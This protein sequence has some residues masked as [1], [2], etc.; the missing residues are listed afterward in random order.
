MEN[1]KKLSF[2]G[3]IFN[4]IFTENPILILMIGM[5]PTLAVTTSVSNA[6]GMDDDNYSTAS[7]MAVILKEAI[8]NETFKELYNTTNFQ[9]KQ[10][11]MNEMR[12]LDELDTYKKAIRE[13]Q[14]ESNQN[15][16]IGR[17]YYTIL[18][19]GWREASTLR[20][21]EDATT[22]I[23]QLKLDNFSLETTNKNL[24][25]DLN[26]IQNNLHEKIIENIRINDALENYEYGIVGFTP[27]KEKVY[28][29]DEM[30]KLVTMLKEDKKNNTE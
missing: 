30:K 17:L 12:N 3:C 19:C 11:H 7:D 6:I 29:I 10:L 1:E 23:N 21:Y 13:L 8:K 24:T 4:G 9:V 22:N 16:L 14:G 27:N 26:D 15:S 20:K 25:K 2:F 5:C 28:P 18:I